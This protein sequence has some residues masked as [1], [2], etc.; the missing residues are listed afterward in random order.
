MSGAFRFELFKHLWVLPKKFRESGKGVK[1]FT[2]QMMFD[3]FNITRLSFIIQIQ[4]SEEFSECLMSITDALGDRTTTISQRKGAIFLIIEIALIGQFLHHT[5]NARLSDPQRL[6]DICHMGSTLALNEFMDAF[7]VVF[8]ALAWD[9]G[10]TFYF[11]YY[12]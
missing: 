5:C 2:A 10:H 7:K 9:S 6:G 12:N 4:K 8:C 11:M 1:G 3:P